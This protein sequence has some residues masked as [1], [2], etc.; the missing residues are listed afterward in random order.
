MFYP[1]GLP[2]ISLHPLSTA[3]DDAL[4]VLST[5]GDIIRLPASRTAINSYDVGSVVG[6]GGVE[7]LVTGFVLCC[8]TS[9][10]KVQLFQDLT[11]QPLVNDWVA[12]LYHTGLGGKFTTAV[13]SHR[14][15]PYPSSRRH[16]LPRAIARRCAPPHAASRP[17]YTVCGSLQ[18]ASSSPRPG[19]AQ[20]AELS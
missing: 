7:L 6:F 16:V 9:E 2:H 11:G 17:Q 4:L 18:S 1:T 14:A 8:A 3:R 19:G 10:V 15:L 12:V 20:L 13:S 5:V